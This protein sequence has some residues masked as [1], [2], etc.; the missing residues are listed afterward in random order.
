VIMTNNES[1][2]L[3]IEQL[4]GG[5]KAVLSVVVNIVKP[6]PFNTMQPNHMQKCDLRPEYT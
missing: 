1:I 4:S 3:Q 2:H 5:Y 6:L